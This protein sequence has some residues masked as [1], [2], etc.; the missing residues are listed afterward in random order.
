MIQKHFNLILLFNFN[1]L[2]VLPK[3]DFTIQLEIL[4]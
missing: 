3:I 2:Y 1:S 4:N